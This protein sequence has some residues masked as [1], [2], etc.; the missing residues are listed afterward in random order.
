MS[1]KGLCHI[2]IRENAT[3]ELKQIGFCDIKHVAGKLNLSDLFTK[4]DK[5]P[6]HFTTIRDALMTKLPE[7]IATAYRCISST[8]IHNLMPDYSNQDKIDANMLSIFYFY[9]LYHLYPLI[10]RGPT[11]RGVIE[12]TGG[13][14]PRPPVPPAT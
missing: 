9:M 6:L 14:V 8:S 10:S 3:R 2:Q 7:A 13:I 1:T 11:M 5:D 4:E 12:G